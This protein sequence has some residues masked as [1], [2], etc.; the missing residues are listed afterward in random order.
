MVFIFDVC[1]FLLP[2]SSSN[3]GSTASYDGLRTLH[4][5]NQ[6]FVGENHIDL[7]LCY[8]GYFDSFPV[9]FFCLGHTSVIQPTRRG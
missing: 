2:A 5:P 9:F 7:K 8:V 6:V 1:R 3:Y 4:L